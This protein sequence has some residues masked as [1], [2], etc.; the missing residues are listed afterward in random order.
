MVADAE[1]EVTQPLGF[2]EIVISRPAVVIFSRVMSMASC[3][4]NSPVVT[5]S[6]WIHHAVDSI[7]PF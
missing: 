5:R 7:H 3:Q 1:P 4:R 2:A 6:L